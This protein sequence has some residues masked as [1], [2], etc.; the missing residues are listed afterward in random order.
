MKDRI[1]SR[2]RIRRH[3][4]TR[5]AAAA[6][7]AVVVHYSSGGACASRLGGDRHTSSSN[8]D[9]DSIY[10][11]KLRGQVSL[12]SLNGGGPASSP[13]EMD[14]LNF[15]SP[16]H[17]SLPQLPKG[18]V[19]QLELNLQDASSLSATAKPRPSVVSGGNN[20][21]GHSNNPD[22]Q[23]SDWSDDEDASNDL[24]NYLP[25][26]PPMQARIVGGN[27]VNDNNKYPWSAALHRKGVH[28]CG[29]VLVAPQVI[30]T[31][32]HCCMSNGQTGADEAI[33][34]T[35]NKRGDDDSLFRKIDPTK[36]RTHPNYVE[37]GYLHDTCLCPIEGDP[38]DPKIIA[39]IHINQNASFPL[40]PSLD[41]SLNESSVGVQTFKT[42]GFGSLN[43]QGRSTDVKME[44]DVAYINQGKCLRAFSGRYVKSDM[45]CAI[46]PGKDACQG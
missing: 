24:L 2:S 36:C 21:N 38:I 17:P 25:P 14:V 44:V 33:L 22:L 20:H 37:R 23:D 45:L 43:E 27:A 39:P 8:A 6:T 42:M 16:R 28:W 26:A 1:A 18:S 32:G 4:G 35:V 29:G 3:N 19:G 5:A 12:S 10:N 31:A 7:V 40:D 15:S 41:Q 9:Q 46:L 34:K 13:F 11:K 30:Q